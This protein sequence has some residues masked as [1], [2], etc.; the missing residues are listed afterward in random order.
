MLNDVVKRGKKRYNRRLERKLHTVSIFKRKGDALKYDNYKEIRILEH[1][2]KVCE[3]LLEKRLRRIII[4]DNVSLAFAL[5][6][7]QLKQYIL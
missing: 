7:L 5:G 4:N 3:K 1:S 2:M 6:D